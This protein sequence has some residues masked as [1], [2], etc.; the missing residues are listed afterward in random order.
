MPNVLLIVLDTVRAD[1][2]GVYG[3]TR[4]TT[5]TLDKLA[6][7]SVVF[8]QAY[9]TA[10]WTFASH[11]SMMTGRWP[12][13]VLS[14]RYA[15]LAAAT[16]TLAEFLFE[17]G[18]DTAGIVANTFYCSYYTGLDRGFAHYRDIPV[19]VINALA[20]TA[21]GS[22][23][24]DRLDVIILRSDP[25]NPRPR[26]HVYRKDA[27]A[28]NHEFLEWFD[29]SERRDRPFFAF[30]NY[31]DAHDP[32]IL[33]EGAPQRFGAGAQTGRT[34]RILLNWWIAT[35][36]NFV[37]SDLIAMLHE[38]Y[39][40]C[41]SD[42]DHRLAE[43][44]DDLD[45]RHALD[46]TYVV[47]TSD[48]GEA[49]GEH[50]LFLHGGSLYQDQLHVPLLILGPKGVPAGRSITAPASLRDLPATIVDLIGAGPSPFPGE[51][52]A[53]LWRGASASSDRKPR[54]VV[55]MVDTPDQFP[56]NESRSPV[57]NGPML[58][59]IDDHKYKYII[60]NKDSRS[61]R[62]ELYALDVDPYEMVNLAES[63]DSKPILLQFQRT[64][65]E[66]AKRG[67]LSPLG[68]K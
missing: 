42:L 33:P 67:E 12:R 65:A 14:D 20:T 5:P 4:P 63:V 7:R 66:M 37:T 60:I 27:D 51:S 30:L 13:E 22:L 68:R 2:I 23:V 31:F 44:L 15:P 29:S 61:P 52:L 59:V 16:P 57:F 39:D 21:I 49:F 34:K 55:A 28:V 32:Y 1:H 45:R 64:I 24:M 25:E 40:S 47:V 48:H 9:A 17:K 35:E 41:L 62:E 54:P 3:Y 50:G 43:L 36:K 10:P 26:L 11:A 46:N 53:A 38:C 58:A 8:K 18:Y 19:T 56:A 6:T